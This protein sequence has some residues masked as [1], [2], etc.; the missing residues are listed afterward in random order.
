MNRRE[1]GIILY[2]KDGQPFF[3]FDQS[4][5]KQF[6]PLQKIPITLQR[7]IITAEDRHFYYH[8]GISLPGIIRAAYLDLRYKKI[9]YGGSTITQQLVK[10]SFFSPAK[11]F[12]RK[13]H[14]ALLAI[15]LERYFSKPEIL[16]MYLNSAYF[17]R[18]VFGVEAAAQTYFGRSAADLNL[19]QAAALASFLPA[20][21]IYNPD[22][23]E[24]SLWQNR[25]Y[26]ILE[27]MQHDNYISPLT[28]IAAELAPLHLSDEGD[29]I[30]KQAPHFALLVRDQIYQTLGQELAIRSGLHVQTTIDLPLQQFTQQELANHITALQDKNAHNGAA[31][32]INPTN[33]HV[34]TLIGSIN[35]QEDK[36]GKINMAIAPRQ[37]GSAI[38]PFIYAA[39]FQ[40][41]ILTPTSPL[42]DIPTTF[43]KDYRPVNYDGRFHGTINVR[44]ALG[45]SLNI[46]AV[47]AAARIGLEKIKQLS[48]AAGLA[49]FADTQDYNLAI[50]LGAKEISLLD[51][52][53]AYGTFAN[54]GLHVPYT[55]VTSIVDKHGKSI[56][57]PI[58]PSKQ[59]IDPAV[60]YQITSILTD[61]ITRRPTFGSLLELPFPVAAKTGTSQ[62]FRD[63]WTIGYTP[64]RLVGIW[65]GNS[66]NTQ[67]NNL[68]G[69]T[70][71][72]PLWKTIMLHL[73]ELS[74]PSNFTQPPSI[75]ATNVCGHI[76]YYKTNNA[77]SYI[78]CP[79]SNNPSPDTSPTAPN[80][81]KKAIPAPL[82]EAAN[83]SNNQSQQ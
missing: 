81:I 15:K 69:A 2:D 25:Q 50:A 51:L 80:P 22:A 16:E 34:L 68:P 30:N 28:R 70:S 55:L 45:N 20:P 42:H 73:A 53:S 82:V 65:I 44:Y 32:I 71:A 23:Q 24:S 77:P 11:N 5:Y 1:T 21:S 56:N 74:P 59:A 41:N 75:I 39:G 17:G 29:N 54:H 52:T 76:E 27:A 62:S 19:A 47:E 67:M 7:A 43:G 64:D 58:S 72:A 78:H 36:F 63:A 13:Y 8:P 83:A 3:T 26:H 46:P 9:I 10:N 35:W 60:A 33:G 48:Q 18:N 79:S 12:T 40:N 57:Y 4:R 37:T 66:N 31:V 61:N 49:A 6:I 14:E 38:K